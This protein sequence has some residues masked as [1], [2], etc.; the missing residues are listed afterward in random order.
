[1][2]GLTMRTMDTSRK[3]CTLSNCPR[4]PLLSRCT[5]LSTTR[6]WCPS[7]PQGFRRTPRHL[8]ST[9]S[10]NL[11]P[12]QR[13]PQVGPFLLVFSLMEPSLGSAFSRVPSAPTSSVPALLCLQGWCACLSLLHLWVKVV[14]PGSHLLEAFASLLARWR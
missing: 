13:A 9:G 2:S 6:P 5:P 3:A 7:T 1:M 8:S 14:D 11:H 12:G 10:P 4:L